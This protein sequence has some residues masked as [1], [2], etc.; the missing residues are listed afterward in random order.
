[1]QSGRQK[2]E[3]DFLLFEPDRNAPSVLPQLV[4]QGLLFRGQAK[5]IAS[6]GLRF[7][8]PELPVCQQC[9]PVHEKRDGVGK[10]SAQLVENGKTVG[11]D[12]PPVKDVLFLQPVDGGQ[13]G[14]AVSGPVKDQPN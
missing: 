8:A 4:V 6:L 3:A 9:L 14:K 13:V 5:E 12:V 2:L 7:A 10:E 1:M 11:V